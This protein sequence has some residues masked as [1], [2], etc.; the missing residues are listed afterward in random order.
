MDVPLAERVRVR[1]RGV[2]RGGPASTLSWKRLK[3][4]DPNSE[5]PC[6]KQHK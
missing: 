3:F 6:S 2:E 5:R 4:L 1:G